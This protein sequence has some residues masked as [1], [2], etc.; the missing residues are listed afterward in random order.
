MHALYLGITNIS[1][2]PKNSLNRG[3][4]YNE[5]AIIEGLAWSVIRNY[6]YMSLKEISTREKKESA[7]TNYF[8]IGH[9]D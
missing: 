2:F 7:L 4:Q 5:P 1:C 6:K 3:F 9:N 8:H